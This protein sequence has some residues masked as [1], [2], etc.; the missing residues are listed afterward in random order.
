MELGG[1]ERRAA[2]RRT[3]SRFVECRA[4]SR[5][6]LRLDFQNII[7]KEFLNCYFNEYMLAFNV[8][9]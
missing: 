7:P 5:R 1:S 9:T 8:L 4:T 3:A 6:S 2:S